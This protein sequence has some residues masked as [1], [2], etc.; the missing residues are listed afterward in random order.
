MPAF[1][2][3]PRSSGSWA[4]LG[5]IHVEEAWRGRGVGRWLIQ[6]AVRWLRLGGKSRVVLPLSANEEAAG[7]GRFYTRFGWERLARLERGWS[8]STAG[9]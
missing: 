7:A 6:H 1:D 4:E 5:P 9:R 8:R 3:G 2:P